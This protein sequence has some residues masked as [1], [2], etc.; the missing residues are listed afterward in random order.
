MFYQNFNVILYLSIKK[1][2]VGP[3][4]YRDSAAHEDAF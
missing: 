3:D 1:D 2:V 4:I